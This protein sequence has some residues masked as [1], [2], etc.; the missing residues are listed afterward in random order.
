MPN[1]QGDRIEMAFCFPYPQV[2]VKQAPNARYYE[3]FLPSNWS[4]HRKYS[5]I[6]ADAPDPGSLTLVEYPFPQKSGA[7]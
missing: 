1:A 5:E 2:L 3:G 6:E 4:S 7:G